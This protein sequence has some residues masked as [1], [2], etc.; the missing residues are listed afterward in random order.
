MS[1]HVTEEGT[2]EVVHEV[3][4]GPMRV[5]G[6]VDGVVNRRDIAIDI[7]IGVWSVIGYSLNIDLFQ[8]LIPLGVGMKHT[9]PSPFELEVADVEIGRGSKLVEE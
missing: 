5:D 9:H 8:F 1:C 3:D 4:V 7:G 6:E 2:G